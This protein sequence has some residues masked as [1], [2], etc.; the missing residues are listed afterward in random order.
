MSNS[1]PTADLDGVQRLR[2][3]AS[4]VAGAAVTE[5]V[6]AADA[7]RVWAL[8]SDF[9]GGF[10]T[11]Q[12]DMRSVRVVERHGDRIGLRAVSRYG[13]RATLNGVLR[14]GYCWLQSRFLVI[15]MAVSAEPGGGARVALTG[16][17]RIPWRPAIVPV[18]VRRESTRTI[19]RLR[20]LL[21]H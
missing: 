18:G 6:L 17:V 2:A 19:E 12:P 5:Q 4:G 10:A 16:G 13:M 1:W 15:G 20:D 8:L 11:V 3:L 14:P 21:G 9:E 7:D